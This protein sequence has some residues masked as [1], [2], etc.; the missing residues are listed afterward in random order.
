MGLCTKIYKFFCDELIDVSANIL[1]NLHI[2]IELNYF[3]YFL[4]PGLLNS[5]FK[6]II[7]QEDV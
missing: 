1:L 7:A 4:H 2:S 6:L 5:T 3:K